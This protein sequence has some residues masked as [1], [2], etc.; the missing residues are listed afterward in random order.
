MFVADFSQAGDGLPSF[1]GEGE[2]LQSRR[3]IF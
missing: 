3:G 1:V 2:S